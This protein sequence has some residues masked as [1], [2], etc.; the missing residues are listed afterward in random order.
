MSA[1][2]QNT[3]VLEYK[4]GEVCR[5]YFT[6]IV[7]NKEG[8]ISQQINKCQSFGKIISKNDEDEKQYL[9]QLFDK[10]HTTKKLPGRC[11][12][13]VRVS[14]YTYEEASELMGS[15]IE[16]NS[17]GHPTMMSIAYVQDSDAGVIINSIPS[18]ELLSDFVFKDTRAPCGKITVLSAEEAFPSV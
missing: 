18:E 6:E 16:S 8:R 15:I 2:I 7:K 3:Q 11:I 12:R 5:C 10:E 13:K 14:P 1:D 9:V 17:C 4:V